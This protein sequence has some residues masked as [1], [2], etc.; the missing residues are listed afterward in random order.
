[1]QGTVHFILGGSGGIGTALAKRL[2]RRGA[3]LVLAARDADKL[4]RVA[5]PLEA[6]T[7]TLE[8]TSF[9][10]VE[11]AIEGAA[12]AHGR[13]D[14]VVNLVGSILIKPAHTTSF[15]E[16]SE[17]LALNLT[18]A[19][20]VVRA[21]ARV[22]TA[23]DHA[24][25][26]SIVLMSSAAAS[27]GLAS[28]EAIAAAKAA[29]AGLTRSAAASYA[30]RK[31]RVNCVSPGLVRTPLAARLTG[32]DASLKASVAMHP[33]GRIGEADDVARA[34]EWLL[35]PDAS[36]VTGQVLGVDGG[37]GSVRPR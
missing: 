28:H 21:A 34:I 29:V 8:G 32:N 23:P 20:A 14:G 6:E 30:P 22:M 7:V 18:S 37:L 13:L 33:L 16:F 31:V 26:G 17:T 25:G 10:E 19:F 3:T 12:S 15:E 2:K 1:M 5:G 4:R 11:R 35:D 36:W 24:G 9:D 27:T